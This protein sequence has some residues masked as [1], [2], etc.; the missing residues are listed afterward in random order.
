MYMVL[1]REL[2]KKKQNALVTFVCAHNIALFNLAH[3][4]AFI[5]FSVYVDTIHR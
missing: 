2:Q 5:Y 4:A 1:D 3:F